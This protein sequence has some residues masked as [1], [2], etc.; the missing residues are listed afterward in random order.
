VLKLNIGD[1]HAPGSPDKLAV[2]VNEDRSA[3][4]VPFT[5]TPTLIVIP[6]AETGN[7]PVIVN[8]EPPL[9]AA[10]ATPPLVE[11]SV[12]DEAMSCVPRKTPQL[13]EAPVP[14]VTEALTGARLGALVVSW[15]VSVALPLPEALMVPV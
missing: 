4:T 11:L 13:T 9:G 1:P 5:V 10:D 12:N 14:M 3:E 15:A 2:P 7:V 8:V 6:A